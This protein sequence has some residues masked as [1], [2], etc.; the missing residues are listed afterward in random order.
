MSIGAVGAALVP[1]AGSTFETS[2][3]VLVGPSLNGPADLEG[4]GFEVDVGPDQSKRLALTQSQRE[5]E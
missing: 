3:A 4:A 1:A 2:A 5:R